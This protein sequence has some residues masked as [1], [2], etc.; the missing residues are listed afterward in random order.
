MNMHVR[1][2]LNSDDIYCRGFASCINAQTIIASSRFFSYG[3]YSAYGAI[4]VTCGSDSFC[5]GDSSCR[6][7][8][9]FEAKDSISCDGY[10]S[11]FGSTF[12]RIISTNS[13]GDINFNG[14]ESGAFITLNLYQSTDIQAR[15]RLSMYNSNINMYIS[16]KIVYKFI[17]HMKDMVMG[18]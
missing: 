2:C 8:G 14:D 4:N 7:I 18:M 9:Y 10:R 13:Y 3:S 17:Y 12:E 16:S 6:N 15:G 11:C 5:Y 1:L